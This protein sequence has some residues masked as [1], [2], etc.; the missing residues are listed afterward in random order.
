VTG[1]VLG[2]STVFVLNGLLA[3]ALFRHARL[4]RLVEGSP[5]VLIDDGVVNERN[6]RHEE[7]CI[8]DLLVA[9]QSQGA[10]DPGEVERAS[11]EPNGT[12]V[13]LLKTPDYETEHFLELRHQLEELKAMV[14]ALGAN[15]GS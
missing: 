15:P 4:R 5:T 1:G 8:E 9:I 12:I 14:S 7:L 2:A 10:K 11:L 13:T 6:L 3:F